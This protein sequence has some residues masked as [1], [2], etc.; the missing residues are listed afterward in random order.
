MARASRRSLHA[1]ATLGDAEL[2]RDLPVRLPCP[3]QTPD[4]ALARRQV[5]VSAAAQPTASLL[6][7]FAAAH[8][9]VTRNQ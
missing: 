4:L 1:S 6:S 3:E 8:S 2:D 7:P 9:P 5:Q